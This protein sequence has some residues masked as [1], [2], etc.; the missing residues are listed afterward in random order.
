[1]STQVMN[2]T[3]VKAG[4]KIRTIVQVGMLAALAVVLMLFE[5]P[6]PVAPSFYEID[7]SEVPVLIGAFAL[8]PWAG[9]IIE[10]IKI[11]LNLVINGTITAFVGEIGNF[12]IGVAFVLPAALIYKHKKSKKTAMIG[13]ATGGI[14]MI[15]ASCFIN[16][17]ILLPA[18]GKAFGMP[19]SAFVDMAAAIHS[20]IN[21]M[22]GFALLCVAPFNLLKVVLVS[23]ITMLLY[24]HISPILKGRR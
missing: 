10:A 9:V 15:V 8:G 18:Y 23:V 6:L 21:S 7:F 2:N 3:N 14:I 12:I 4:T 13:L 1:M 22:A 20:S 19:V 16:V 24:K 5:I 11:L 17:F